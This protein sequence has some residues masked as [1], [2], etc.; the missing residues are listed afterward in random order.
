VVVYNKF[1]IIAFERTAGFWRAKIRRADG[2]MTEHDGL[3]REEF[4]TSDA[5]TA[6]E[7]EKMAT[8]AIDSK[9]FV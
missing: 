4:E 7:A 5:S 6:A 3:R 1:Q 9:W 8:D 2:T